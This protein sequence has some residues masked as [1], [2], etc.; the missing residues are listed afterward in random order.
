[1]YNHDPNAL[2]MRVSYYQFC[3]HY[4]FSLSCLNSWLLAFC[5]IQMM[6]GFHPR[7]SEQRQDRMIRKCW[8]VAGP[9]LSIRP[10]LSLWGHQFLTKNNWLASYKEDLLQPWVISA[11]CATGGCCTSLL[12]GFKVRQKEVN[13][14]LLTVQLDSRIWYQA[15]LLLLV[16][17]HFNLRNMFSPPF[18]VF[19]QDTVVG[20]LFFRL[21]NS[22]EQKRL[23]KQ[24]Q[25]LKVIWTLILKIFA[26]SWKT[27]VS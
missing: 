10:G 13:K 19:Q 8:V 3:M 27:S 11:L 7:Q 16:R 17:L 1:M 21:Q 24:I 14:G 25:C 18:L 5:Q 9:V 22:L 12:G 2:F 20:A 6:A 15:P 26:L 4:W 23:P